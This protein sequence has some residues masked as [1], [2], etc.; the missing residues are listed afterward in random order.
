MEN[1]II[2]DDSLYSRQRYVLGDKAMNS[3]T[4]SNVLLIG[5]GGLGIE[6]AKNIVLAGIKSLSILDNTRCQNSDLGGQFLIR[7]KDILEN[8]TRAG[9]SLFR[10]QEL[11]SYVSVRIEENEL[12]DY[13]LKFLLQYQCIVATELDLNQLVTLNNFCR[14]NNIKFVSAD[15][16]GIFCWTFCDFGQNFEVFDDNGE[17]PRDFFVGNINQ[18]NPGIVSTFEFSKHQLDTG[19]VVE[20]KEVEG[21]DQ[22]NN[23]RF[24]V[25]VISPHSFSI[26][27]TSSFSKY[28]CGG[29][30]LQIKTVKK[31]NFDNLANQ[32]KAPKYLTPDLCKMDAPM[33]I[34]VCMLALHRFQEQFKRM[35]N[36]WCDADSDIFTN[37]ANSIC[38]ENNYLLGQDKGYFIDF[39]R[40]C[41]GQFGPL[42]AFL[43]G[44]VAQEILKACTGKF[45]PLHQWLHLDAREVL[46]NVT[47]NHPDQFILKNDRYDLMRKCIG[48]DMLNQLANQKIFMVGCGAIGCELLK[49]FANLGLGTKGEIV[50]TDNDLIEKSNLNRQFLFR[51]SH[52]QKAK[53]LTASNAILDINAD[54]NIISYQHKVCS[55]TENTI[56]ND[57]FFNR[58]DVHVNALDNLESRRYMDGRCVTNQ[59]PLLDSGTMSTKGHVQVIV[60]FLTESYTSQVD[61]VDTES[62][63]YC[64]LRSFPSNMIHCIEWARDKFE[65]TFVQKPATYNE[66]WAKNKISETIKNVA[67][68]V[69]LKDV[70]LV[71]R[72]VEK[73]PR[74]WADCLRIARCKFESR[75]NHNAKQLLHCFPLDT[76]NSDGTRFWQLPKRPPTPLL[77]DFSNSIHSLYI[78]SYSKLLAFIFGIIVNEGDLSNSCIINHLNLIEVPGFKHKNKLIET[79][80]SAEKPDA[81][82]DVEDI[83]L[84][85]RRFQIASQKL[86]GKE[87]FELQKVEFEKDDDNNGHI[88]YIYAASCL[89]AM[90]YG[91]ET[92]ERLEVKRIAGRIIP[93]IATTTAAVAGLVTI[94]LIKIINK[95]ELSSYRNCFLNLSLPIFVLSEPAEVKKTKLSTGMEFNL[96]DRWEIKGNDQTTVGNFMEMVKQKYGRDPVFIV[97]NMKFIYSAQM[98][99]MHKKRIPQPIINH[100]KKNNDHNYVDLIIAFKNQDGEEDE[101]C[102]QIRYY[103]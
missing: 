89:R 48:S 62:I 74:S 22:V 80:E 34:H 87:P 45:T 72:W 96:W 90:M 17:E 23:R 38:S 61:P 7:E 69:E 42:C 50:I 20:F 98:H 56:F 47:F 16:Y 81:N 3:L 11:N 103:F 71:S 9:A 99:V 19:D 78:I 24:D 65:T 88:D 21:M 64:T 75:F 33:Y 91:I 52:V 55:E 27:D 92:V 46:K 31:L 35:P 6:I 97:Q 67:S 40:T 73:M 53:S 83:H 39:S 57:E 100:I 5:I 85:E 43:G 68:G 82:S 1:N 70:S 94:E 86:N 63:P 37:I 32:L 93:A 14:N 95:M 84:V 66:F 60:P 76:K 58:M 28:K 49:N 8:K 36:T 26:C 51:S 4:R 15:V 41:D 2:I 29:R 10:L 13:S 79:D 102:P 30:A 25:K 44:V 77:F 101:I 18:S 12:R 54:M 59:K